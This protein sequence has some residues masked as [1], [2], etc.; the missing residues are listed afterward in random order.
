MNNRYLVA[1]ICMMATGPALAAWGEDCEYAREIES[2]LDVGDAS[3][4]EVIARAGTLT[5]TGDDDSSEVLISGEVC[6]SREAWLD[7]ADIETDEGDT[8][9]IEV[10]LPDIDGGWTNWGNRYARIDL[11]LTVPAGLALDIK[12]SSGSMKLRGI[13]ESRIKDSSGSITVEDTGGSVTVKD[14]SG[15]IRFARI[16]GDVIIESDSAGSISGKDIRGSVLVKKDSSGSISF[17]AVDGDFTVERD[18]SG[19]I[20]ADGVGGN[21]MVLKDG[22]GGIKARNVSGSIT[23]PTD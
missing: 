1:L 18:S 7:E 5:I 21:F 4:L 11:E 10:V 8:A 19:S 15:S 14:S 6:V 9:R 3:L 20:S 12:D 22:S 16:G 17:T 2:R 13:G 23:K